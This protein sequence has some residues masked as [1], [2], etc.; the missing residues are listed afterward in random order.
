[1]RLLED[2]LTHAREALETQEQRLD[3][4]SPRNRINA[5]RQRVDEL[6]IRAQTWLRHDLALQG[7]RLGGLWAQLESLSPLAT[8]DRGYA[9]VHHSD[10]G[11]LITRVGQVRTGDEL[12]VHV[13]DGKFGVRAD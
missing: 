3:R 7:E 10:A 12:E 9:L 1:M 4:A 2:R 13:S 6:L 11:Q 8:L 5:A